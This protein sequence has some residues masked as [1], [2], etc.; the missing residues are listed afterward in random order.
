MN[1]VKNEMLLGLWFSKVGVSFNHKE[2]KL[3]KAKWDGVSTQP[4]VEI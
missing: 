4:N 2:N 1:I 3:R